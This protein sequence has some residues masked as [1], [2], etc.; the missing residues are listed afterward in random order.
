MVLTAPPGVFEVTSTVIVQPPAGMVAPL[1]YVIVPEPGPAVTVP[2]QVPPILG[3]VATV[4]P[5]GRVSVN[6]A[7]SVAA[8]ALVLPSDMVR[9]EV[10]PEVILVGLKA[11]LIVGAV[12]VTVRVSEAGAALLP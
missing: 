10:L 1:A 2:A 5:A 12:A 8:V 4:I 6:T 9:V 3:V 11:L 7:E